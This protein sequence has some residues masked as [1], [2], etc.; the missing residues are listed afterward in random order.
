[1]TSG[2]ESAYSQVVHV[3]A[4]VGPHPDG[5]DRLEGPAESRA[6]HVGVKAPND[7]ACA[8]GA[9]PL[10][11]SRGCESDERR[12]VLVRRPRIEPEVKA[13]PGITDGLL[14]LSVGLED[15][16]DLWDDLARALGGAAVR[17]RHVLVSVA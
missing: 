15:V 16:E 17:T 3:D 6:V 1:M 11:A 8:E 13:E 4:R 10:E 12:E 2:S 14:R 9:H 7:P 5:D